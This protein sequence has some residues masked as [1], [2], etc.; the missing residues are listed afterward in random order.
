LPGEPL[1]GF[2]LTDGANA[3]KESP[4]L[5]GLVDNPAIF[6]TTAKRI[7]TLPINPQQLRAV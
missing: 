7:R 1:F 5:V 2:L 4:A 6:A 3:A